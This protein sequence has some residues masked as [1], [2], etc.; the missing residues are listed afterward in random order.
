MNSKLISTGTVVALALALTVAPAIAHGDEEEAHGT[1]HEAAETAKSGAPEVLTAVWLDVRASEAELQELIHNKELSKVHETAFTL[2][3]LVAAMPPKSEQL[4]A[5]Q[6]KKLAGNVKF[7]ATLA[8]RLDTSGDAGDQAAT[9]AN[10]KQ[11]QSVL[12]SIEGLYP[13][14]VLK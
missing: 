12:T 6:Q 13:A 8:E 14:G 3:D 9:E 11:L 2:R 4:S 7:V 5:E 1:H 10:F